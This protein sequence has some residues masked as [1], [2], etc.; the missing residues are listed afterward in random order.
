MQYLPSNMIQI[1]FTS[2]GFTVLLQM[3][4]MSKMY[5]KFKLFLIL[6]KMLVTHVNQ[7]LQGEARV[8]D[9]SLQL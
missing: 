9:C 3:V 8:N 2:L 7:S 5:A 6:K 4:V 1:F